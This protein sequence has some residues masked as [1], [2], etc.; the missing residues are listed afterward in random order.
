MTISTRI[1]SLWYGLLR[2]DDGE[3]MET[4]SA[5]SGLVKRTAVESVEIAPNDP[6]VAYFQSNPTLVETERLNLDSPALLSLKA[7]GVKL[8]IPLSVR[9]ACPRSSSQAY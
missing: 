3:T 9:S 4:P 2:N 8:A 7:A 6:L 5:A 1:Q